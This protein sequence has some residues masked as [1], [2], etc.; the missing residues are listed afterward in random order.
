MAINWHKISQMP[1]CHKNINLG[2]T[3]SF[4]SN[5][6]ILFFKCLFFKDKSNVDNN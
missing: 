2:I 3:W 6:D 4:L 1:L 5:F